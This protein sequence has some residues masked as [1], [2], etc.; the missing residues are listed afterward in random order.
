MI[1][2]DYDSS[3]LLVVLQSVVRDELSNIRMGDRLTQ[4]VHL[5]NVEEGLWLISCCKVMQF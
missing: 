2:E 3:L 1:F 5:T 4:G